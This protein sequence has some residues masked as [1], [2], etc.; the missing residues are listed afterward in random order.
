MKALVLLLLIACGLLHADPLQPQGPKCVCVEGVSYEGHD[1]KSLPVNDE[2]AC[3]GLCTTTPGCKMGV[4]AEGKHGQMICRLTGSKAHLQKVSGA[5]SCY[6]DRTGGHSPKPKL[7]PRPKPKPLPKPRPSDPL[8][9]E[10]PPVSTQNPAASGYTPTA[11][12]G[13]AVPRYNLMC[14]DDKRKPLSTNH[15]WVPAVLGPNAAGKN[16]ITTLPYVVNCEKYGLE[17]AYPWI[18]S[19]KKIVQNIVNRHWSISPGHGERYCVRLADEVTF[20]VT[21][22]GTMESTIVRGSPY[23]TATFHKAPGATVGTAQGLRTLFIDED[24]IPAPTTVGAEY[25]PKRK[26]TAVLRDSDE[27]WVIYLPPSTPVTI[28]ASPSSFGIGFHEGFSGVVRLAMINNCTTGLDGVSPHCPAKDTPNEETDPYISDY[29]T[30]IDEGS[31]VCTEKAVVTM[32][33]APG[34]TL[35]QYHYKDYRC[36][37]SLPDGL[38][39]MVALPH[40]LAVTPC[41]GQTRVILSG[42]H[43]N[44]R[45]L[46]LALQL[47]GHTWPLLY[48]DYSIDWIGIPDKSKIPTILWALKGRN[49]SSDEHYDIRYDMK[50]GMIDPYNAGKLFAK[51]G[52]LVLI[53]D[54]LGEV[55]IRDKL[56]GRLRT[57]ISR[58]YDHTTKNLLIYDKSWGGIISCGCRYIWI[59]QPE[60]PEPHGYPICANNGS[61]LECPTFQDPN[62]D[63]GNAYYNDHHFHYGYF[64]YSSAVIAKFDPAWAEQYNEKVLALIRDIANPSPK[65]PYFTTFR[66]FD[67]FVGHSWALGIYSDPNG[68]GQ[69]STSEAVNAWYG[70]HL[71]GKATNQPLLALVG[72]T[73]VQ[74]EVHSTNYY[75]HVP[76][77]MDIYPREFKHTIVGIVHDL[78]IE[79]QTYFGS[80]GFFV[81]GIQLLPITPVVHL[82]FH[83]FWV[84]WGYPRFHEYCSNDPFCTESGFVTFMIAE[85]AMIDK[86][87]AWEAALKLPDHVFSLEC[88]GGNGNSLTNT[89][90]FISAWGNERREKW[91][92]DEPLCSNWEFGSDTTD[93][94]AL[95]DATNPAVAGDHPVALNTDPRARRGGWLWLVLLPALALAAAAAVYTHRGGDL[96]ALAASALAWRPGRP[97]EAASLASQGPLYGTGE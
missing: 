15:W 9:K 58:W 77:N 17:L 73:L 31:N 79:F 53:S 36:W 93:T 29:A 39:T 22:G 54:Q 34:G 7:A 33:K 23:I 27:S 76:S 64:I 57:Y 14:F 96:P 30:A 40:H 46:S 18:M 26:I 84:Q 4:M 70:I 61:H 86:E 3:C 55:E 81:H 67:F 97:D 43:R 62:F 21:W 24:E 65:D 75:W 92:S 72:E 66:Y 6:W 83:P 85:Q 32:E 2:G 80:A 12:S 50:D 5:K 38:L 74:M 20:T 19:Q 95:R 28:K 10:F 78:I 13:E 47:A 37:P 35:V 45:G 48:P 51:L 25:T 69:E 88:A 63:F 41:E 60:K 1:L 89:L 82:M 52:R 68:K 44:L 42:G 56:L 16:Y 8:P 94:A 11:R 71:Y 49:E 87:G 91:L 90:Y 59:S